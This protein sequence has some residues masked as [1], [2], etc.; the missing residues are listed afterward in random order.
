MQPE[1]GMRVAALISLDYLALNPGGQRLSGARSKLPNPLN[2]RVFETIA[3]EFRHLSP[4]FLKRQ[5]EHLEIAALNSFV[6][7]IQGFIYLDD[8]RLEC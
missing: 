6:I 1:R 7:N 8:L 4:L 2:K 3:S 5:G